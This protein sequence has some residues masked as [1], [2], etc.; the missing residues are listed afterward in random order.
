MAEYPVSVLFCF[1]TPLP[2]PL[3]FESLKLRPKTPPVVLSGAHV[4][5]Y[6]NGWLS[7]GMHSSAIRWRLSRLRRQCKIA[8]NSTPPKYPRRLWFSASCA[9][10]GSLQFGFH[11]VSR[12]KVYN[13]NE[14]D[15]PD[16]L[17]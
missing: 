14:R 7:L 12:L 17:T 16:Q 3:V 13:T 10:L 8:M 6:C 1:S 11:L 15:N 2:P 4:C 5:L 9:W